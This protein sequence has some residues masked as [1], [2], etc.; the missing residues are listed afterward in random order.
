[1][2]LSGQPDNSPE[3]ASGPP[4]APPPRQSSRLWGGALLA[5]VALLLV[6]LGGIVLAG[7]M[8]FGA[9]E[10]GAPVGQ[11]Q[12]ATT[13][14]A[15]ATEGA[16]A[17]EENEPPPATLELP[18]SV[19]TPTEEPVRPTPTPVSAD[20]VP[21]SLPIEKLIPFTDSDTGI[22]GLR[23]KSWQFFGETLDIP[24]QFS[25]SL[26]APDSFLFYLYPT[27]EIAGR[28]MRLFAP[29]ALRRTID[30]FMPHRS[31]PDILEEE[32]FEDGNT[33]LLIQFTGSAYSDS[34]LEE[35][36]PLRFMAYGRA[37]VTPHG[38]IVAVAMVPAEKFPAE[39]DHIREMV[40]S[41]KVL[42]E[43]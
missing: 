3:H 1:M 20:D 6:V 15:S 32:F 22:T 17:T 29:Q 4:P 43:G 37:I 9:R 33:L 40:D 35:T 26:E 2:S 30:T 41:L 39:E 28:D 7:S 27:E 31:N 11:A 38:V 25:S 23:P 14:P 19:P 21:E 5:M 24:P 10:A 18:T 16:T 8:L 34:S 42:V 12:T 36:V 13:E